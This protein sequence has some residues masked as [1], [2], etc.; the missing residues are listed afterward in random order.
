MSTI[1]NERMT[2]IATMA[3]HKLIEI[4]KDM[5]QRFMLEEICMYDREVD[6]FNVARKR[7]A[8]DIEWDLDD[9]CEDVELPSEVDVP[10]DV[11]DD[12]VDDWLSDVYGF[13]VKDFN[14]EEDDE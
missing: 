6:F 8:T 2:E 11:Y 7:K 4:D 9:D 14:L 5:A 13:C 1:N 12:D 3:L 10:Y